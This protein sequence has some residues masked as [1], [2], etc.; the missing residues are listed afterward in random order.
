MPAL[1]G[2]L[3]AASYARD[4]F[5]SAPF[6]REVPPAIVRRL[7]RWAERLD[8]ELGPAS[9]VRAV[10]D[11]AVL[12]LLEILGYPLLARHDERTYATLE[13]IGRAHV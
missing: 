9:S 4:L 12:P 5:S 13:E 1:R 3:I 7:E 8:N 10:A 6:A 2:R 11:V